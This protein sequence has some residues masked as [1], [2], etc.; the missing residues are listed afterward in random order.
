MQNRPP[1]KPERP[2]RRDFITR[3]ID[4]DSMNG[5]DLL[6]ELQKLQ[7]SGI[8]LSAVEVCILDYS[9]TLEWR[10]AEPVKKYEARM[11]KYEAQIAVYHQQY[12]AWLKGELAAL[13]DN[14]E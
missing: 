3:E 1:Y 9:A 14:G 12:E 7:K 2:Y 8:E 5:E 4:L 6:E 10:E 13:E 11:K